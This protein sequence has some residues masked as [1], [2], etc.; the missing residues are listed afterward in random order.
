MTDHPT[1]ILLEK[2]V[3]TTDDLEAAERESIEAHL[4]EC[5][6]CTQFLER[7]RVFYRNLQ[8]DLESSPADRD[9]EVAENILRRK[10]FAL[11]ER[12]S[13]GRQ[14]TIL[15]AVVKVIEPYRRPTLQRFVR[16]ARVHPVRF[17][18]AALATAM[19][20]VVAFNILRPTSDTNPVIGRIAH[21]VLHV[22][23]KQGGELWNLYV[24]DIPDGS[25]GELH[26]PL[27]IEDIDGDDWNEVLLAGVSRTGIFS[28]DTLYCF[29]HNGSIK[30]KYWTGESIAYGKIDAFAIGRWIVRQLLTVKLAGEEAHR[31]F[32]L[33]GNTPYASPMKFSEVDGKTGTER[34]AYYQRGGIEHALTVDVDED[35]RKEIL[36]AGTNN[37]FDMACVAILDPTD[38]HGYGPA[39]PDD[40]PTVVP[41]ANVK[42]YILF[43]RTQLAKVRSGVKFNIVNR[44]IPLA[45]SNLT[46]QVQEVGSEPSGASVLYTFGP[47]MRVEA[48]W[49]GSDFVR[50][51]EEL[52]KAGKL[53]EILDEAYWE[54][55]KKSVLYWDG[56][57]FVTTPTLNKAFLETHKKAPLP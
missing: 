33:S 28:D 32:I 9:W 50:V 13:E 48:V 39:T 35:G 29:N 27:L 45:N 41:P 19:S 20:L 46:I 5:A 43:P 16:Y 55:L 25:S 52:V 26:T 42:Y 54:K 10:Q 2:F 49:R 11:P 4:N 53:N 36:L 31:L 23:N 44:V 21:G 38:F 37:S 15:D 14:L 7:L 56:E 3:V 1:E 18:G 6:L 47:N 57:K 24:K 51:H 8:A 17:S 22:Y 30:W 12:A 40:A 34:Q